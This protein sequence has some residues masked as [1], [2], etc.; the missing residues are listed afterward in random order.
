MEFRPEIELRE[1]VD[2]A[3]SR[4]TAEIEA[5]VP[6]AEVEHVG[7]TA[8][9]GALTKGD[10]DLLVSVPG[11]GFD[12]AVAALRTR[13]AINQPDNWTTVFASFAVEPAGEIPVGVQLVVAG[14][15][16][17]RLFREW[18]DRLR[19]DSELLARYNEFKRSQAGTEP[20]AYIDAKAEFIE[21]VIGDGMGKEGEPADPRPA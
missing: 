6:G 14:G 3:V 12:E 13:Y 15:A 9:P 1:R 21:A 4:H 16:D 17:E 7:A 11:G 19:S 10:V 20:D 8:V 18:R 5:L 2:A